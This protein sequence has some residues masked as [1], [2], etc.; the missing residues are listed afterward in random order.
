MRKCNQCLETKPLTEFGFNKSQPEGKG[1]MC[2]PC[3]RI[4]DKKYYAADPIKGRA[5]TKKHKDIKVPLNR[6]IIW[7][8]IQAPCHDCGLVDPV[9]ME[10]DHRPDEVKLYDIGRMVGNTYSLETLRVEIA[11]CD[12]VCANCH[13][14]RT[15]K[16]GNWWRSSQ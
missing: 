1:Y 4:Y 9:V 16:R 3:R 10:F 2:K 11:K 14:R 6:E 15:N 5:K 12:V 13:R 8:A 7:E